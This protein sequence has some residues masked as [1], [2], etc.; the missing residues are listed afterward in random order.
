[1]SRSREQQAYQ[2]AR[3]LEAPC[4]RCRHQQ[5]CHTGGAA[6]GGWAIYE[7]TWVTALGRC[8]VPGCPCPARRPDN[9]ASDEQGAPECD[10]S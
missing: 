9:A 5:G 4:G 10:T 6:P 2:W 7:P 8:T 1:M 3:L